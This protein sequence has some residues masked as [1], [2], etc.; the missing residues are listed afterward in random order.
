MYLKATK[1]LPMELT[2]FCHMIGVVNL[3]LAVC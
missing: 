3:V 1:K 2:F